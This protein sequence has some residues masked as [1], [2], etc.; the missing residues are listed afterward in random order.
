MLTRVQTATRAA[1]DAEWEKAV[2][3]RLLRQGGNKPAF[4]TSGVWQSLDPA[5]DGELTLEDLPERE[6]RPA[7][8][9]TAKPTTL[10]NSML[11]NR[12]AFLRV[13]E[14]F[15]AT[16]RRE[17]H[18]QRMAEWNIRHKLHITLPQPT[19]EQCWNQTELL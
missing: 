8:E 12:A 15:S 13:S 4:T 9:G 10:R 16:S 14:M 1:Q 7:I 6:V 5:T 19:L 17:A 2:R 11:N 3:L 18:A